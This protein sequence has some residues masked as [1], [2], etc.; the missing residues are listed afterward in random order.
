MKKQSR[1]GRFQVLGLV[2]AAGMM[3]A[4]TAGGADFT[5]SSTGYWTNPV[6]WGDSPGD[7][8]PTN[9][10]DNVYIQS[11]DTVTID[12][13]SQISIN[14]L[15]ITGTLAHAQNGSTDANIINLQITG[16]LTI[17]AAGKIDVTGK[18]YSSGGVGGN[19]PA[20]SHG[21]QG[22]NF[23]TSDAVGPTYDSITNPVMSGAKGS[24]GNGGGVVLLNIGGTA[25]INGNILAEGNDSTGQ[26]GGGAGG[27][28][29]ITANDITGSG[30]NSVMGGDANKGGGSGGGGRMAI[31]TAGSG[32]GSLVFS[33]KAGQGWSDATRPAGSYYW[34]R[35][36]AAGT[37]YLKESGD[38][39]GSLLVNA[40]GRAS[41][42]WT[43]YTNA[44]CQFDTITLTNHGHLVVGSN[45]TLNLT[46]C[47][48][49]SDS[50]TNSLFLGNNNIDPDP[51]TTKSRLLIGT[52]G[53]SVT[54]TGTLTN[55]GCISWTGT[56][57]TSV[58]GSL[59]VPSG[60]I[61]THENGP[62]HAINLD[63]DGDLTVDSGGLIWVK[64]RGY[65]AAS[66][67]PGYSIAKRNGGTH[68]G[69][70]GRSDAGGD[71]GLGYPGVT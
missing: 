15:S 47:K 51:T 65:G 18:G 16:G 17:D 50:T 32:F 35:N 61:L 58:S 71:P 56:N 3:L 33:A 25:T 12:G 57:Q 48:L 67:P 8:T 22:G 14:S 21:G 36:G 20:G 37:I 29:N 46:G 24:M 13:T 26:G 27:T 70:G 39:Y 43:Y 52:A 31:V 11:S 10:A 53:S 54:W 69:Q 6:T 28:I 40:E 59:T 4:G 34:G 30:T 68:G 63:L 19:R 9:A 49:Y 23:G 62:T 5:S 45:A 41:Q 60:G 42:W 7:P 38:T 1:V 55:N 44:T 2:L 66:G 64:A